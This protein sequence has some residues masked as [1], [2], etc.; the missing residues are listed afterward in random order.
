MGMVIVIHL[1]II[2]IIL[3]HSLTIGR[4]HEP[5]ELH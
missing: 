5:L 2:L 4:S 3:G 1:L